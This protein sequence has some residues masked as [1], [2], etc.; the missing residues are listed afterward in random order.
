[1]EDSACWIYE[2][3]AKVMLPAPFRAVL[4]CIP[5]WLNSLYLIY[6]VKPYFSTVPSHW[7]FPLG[8]FWIVIFGIEGVLCRHLVPTRQSWFLRAMD[9][10]TMLIAHAPFPFP[11]YHNSSTLSEVEEWVALYYSFKWCH[12]CC[13][14]DGF[15]FNLLSHFWGHSLLFAVNH[16]H[17]TFNLDNYAMFWILPS[18]IY[19][20]PTFALY[21]FAVSVVLKKDLSTCTWSLL[22]VFPNT[23]PSRFD[24]KSE[25]SLRTLSLPIYFCLPYIVWWR[26]LRIIPSHG[27]SSLEFMGGKCSFIHFTY[28]SLKVYRPYVRYDDVGGERTAGL[29]GGYCSHSSILFPTWYVLHARG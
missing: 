19:R 10:H 5:F 9:A 26:S 11:D 14:S 8:A 18:I 2:R 7:S 16:P 21:F 29:F 13:W 3:S 23:I 28:F 24:E 22:P 17:H 27:F 4:F 20:C 25:F 1:M 6:K 15:P 12:V